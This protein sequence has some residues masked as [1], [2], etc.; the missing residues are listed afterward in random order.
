MTSKQRFIGATAAM[1]R[2]DPTQINALRGL[3]CDDFDALIDAFRTDSAAQLE[4]IVQAVARCDSTG[5]RL[6]AHSLK[7]ACA[8]LGADDLAE[9][10]GRI[11]HL[12]RAGGCAEAEMLLGALHIELRAVSAALAELMSRSLFPPA[13]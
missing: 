2:L 11:E 12:G 1:A 8:N 10:C 13:D 5:L 3:M 7:G 4:A 9:L 6:Q